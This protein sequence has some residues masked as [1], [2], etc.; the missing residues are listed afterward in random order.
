MTLP[1]C[2]H[3]HTDSYSYSTKYL[4]VSTIFSYQQQNRNSL[5]LVVITN[6]LIPPLTFRLVFSLVFPFVGFLMSS[7][8]VV[9]PVVDDL[10]VLSE[11]HCEKPKQLKETLN[12]K[13]FKK[14]KKVTQLQKLNKKQQREN[15]TQKFELYFQFRIHNIKDKKCLT[16]EH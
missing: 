5:D 9:C 14:W 4:K 10:L 8:F 6:P 11:M 13:N 2:T 12:L 7:I 1:L 15:Y 16:I 3:T